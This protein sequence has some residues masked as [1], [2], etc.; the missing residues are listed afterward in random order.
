MEMEKIK[1]EAW[2]K[3][4]WSLYAYI[5]ARCMDYKGVLDHRH[6]RGGG[7]ISPGEKRGIP[8]GEAYPTMTKNGEIFGHDDFNCLD[9]IEEAGLVENMG[10]GILPVC[11]FTENGYEILKQ[12]QKHR[13]EGG[14]YQRFTPHMS[15]SPMEGEE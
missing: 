12:L 9:D 2:G 6:M 15:H 11:R 10:T 13:M 7:T 5:G 3:D 1:I 4:H 8:A 14:N